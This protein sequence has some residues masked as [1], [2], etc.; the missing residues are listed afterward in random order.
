MKIFNLSSGS[1]GNVTLI[2]CGNFKILIDAGTT[3]KY[4]VASLAELG[5]T[6]DEI[7]LVLVTHYHVDH[8]KSIHTFDQS[9]V[10][11]NKDQEEHCLLKLNED[12]IYEK[13]CIKPFLL[14]HDSMCYGYQIKY[15]D[16]VLTYIT[17]TGYVKNDYLDLIKEADYLYLEFNHDIGKLHQTSRPPILKQRILSDNGHLNNHDAAYIV[18]KGKSNKLKQLMVAHISEEANTI[19]LIQNEIEN[20][21][22]SFDQEIDFDILYTGHQTITKAGKIDEN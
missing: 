13:V 1:K 4:I 19:D 16:E 10:K 22:N 20:V 8:A 6:M 15:D 21:F 3:K 17:D 7:D 2:V 14:S 11:S 12:N 18:Y 9:K 5:Y